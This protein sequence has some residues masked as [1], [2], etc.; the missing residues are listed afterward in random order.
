M[1]QKCGFNN[2]KKFQKCAKNAEVLL[3][4]NVYYIVNDNIEID[5]KQ[6]LYMYIPSKHI[7]LV[8]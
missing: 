7:S 3:I 5:N 4:N 1:F 6:F 8:R 2:E